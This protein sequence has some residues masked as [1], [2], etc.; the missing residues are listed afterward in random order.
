MLMPVLPL[1]PLMQPMMANGTV[2]A[3]VATTYPAVP[4]AWLSHAESCLL[5]K[6]LAAHPHSHQHCD[7]VTQHSSCNR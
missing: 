5:H 6:A 2:A 7:F 4:G 1:L 3:A